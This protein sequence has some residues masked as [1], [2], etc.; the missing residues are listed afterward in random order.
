[1]NVLSRA[2]I[3]FVETLKRKGVKYTL[4]SVVSKIVSPFNEGLFTAFSFLPILND[5]IVFESEGDLT[6]N[7]FALYNYLVLNGYDRKYRMIWAVDNLPKARFR[8]P[9]ITAFIRKKPVFI[10]C[11][12]SYYLAR[13]RLYI[14]DHV[15]LLRSHRKREGQSIINLWHGCAIKAAKGGSG[16]K[17]NED[18]LLVTGD[19]WKSSMSLFVGCEENKIIALGYPRNDCFFSQDREES[20]RILTALGLKKN[21]KTIIWMPTFRKSSS[22]SLSEEYFQGETGLPILKENADLEELNVFLENKNAT[23]VIK[24]HHLQMDYSAFQKKYSNIVF[25]KDE[26]IVGVSIQLYQLVAEM[27]ALITD[28]SSVFNDYLLLDR[29]IIFTLDDYE[30][31]KASRGF[32]LEDPIRY[33]PGHHVFDKQQLFEAIGEVINGGDPFKEK[34]HELQPLLHQHLDGNSCKRIADY[35]GL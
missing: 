4:I 12:R 26:D 2:K 24:V 5:L 10:D 31:Y 27:D 32:L 28:Y 14:F 13:C 30:E 8:M 11:R 35:I 1:M 18:L 21:A 3:R 15:N 25:L 16:K 6:D 17:N 34:R 23:M 29:P 19:F 7:A 9:A 20:C 33:F 22:I